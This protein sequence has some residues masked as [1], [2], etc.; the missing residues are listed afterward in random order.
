MGTHLLIHVGHNLREA[1]NA[2]HCVLAATTGD[3][4][5]PELPLSSSMSL[6]DNR[7]KL[8]INP[9]CEATMNDS[10]EPLGNTPVNTCGFTI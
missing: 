1:L 6:P 7:R 9:L 2:C 3:C 5:E 10:E 8:V 4:E